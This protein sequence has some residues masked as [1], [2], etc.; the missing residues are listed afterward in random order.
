MNKIDSEKEI[1]K[2]HRREII[3]KNIS[4]FKSN[5]IGMTG[6]IIIIIFGFLALLSSIIFVWIMGSKDISSSG[7][8]R[9]N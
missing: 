4:L 3:N 5:K 8:L 1:Q 7:R 6:L 2:Q 9:F